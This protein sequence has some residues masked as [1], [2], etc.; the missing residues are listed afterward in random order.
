MTITGRTL[1]GGFKEEKKMS[2]LKK[3]ITIILFAV[4]A[5]TISFAITGF[6]AKAKADTKAATCPTSGV[7]EINDKV[8]LKLNEDGG[9]R[10]ILKMDEAHFSYIKGNE[11]VE[12]GF[13]IAPKILMD[14][15][16]EDYY[17]MQKKIVVTVDKEKIYEL[18]NKDGYHYA[19]GCVIN[20]KAVNRKYDY[21][22]AAYIK[23]GEKIE[24]QAAVNE[25]SVKSFYNVSNAAILYSGE[26]YSEKM[27]GLTA[28]DWL[29]TEEYPIIVSDS[30]RY[31]TLKNRQNSGFKDKYYE[32]STDVEYNA[33]DVSGIGSNVSRYG[34]ETAP[35]AKGGLIYTGSAQELVEAGTATGENCKIMYKVEGGEWGEFVPVAT[36]AGEY[37]VCYKAIKDSLETTEKSLTVNIAKAKNEITYDTDAN[38]NIVGLD[39]V[40]GNKPNETTAKALAGDITYT[41]TLVSNDSTAD[42][43]SVVVPDGAKYLP[44]NDNNMSGLYKCLITVSETENYKSVVGDR[45]VR[46]HKKE[47]DESGVKYAYDTT[48]AVYYVSGCE[49][50]VTEVTVPGIFNDGANGEHN[51]T[52][53]AV[54]AL[55]NKPQLKKVT[56]HE[57]IKSLNGGV[58]ANDVKLEY[59]LMTGVADLAYNSSE[60]GSGRGNNFIN[61]TALKYVIMNPAFTTDV[62]QFFLNGGNPEKAILDIYVDAASGTPSFAEGTNQN[63]L[64][65]NIYHK[66]D[67]AATVKCLQW[68]YGA[69][70]EIVKG[71]S[72]HIF[73]DGICSECGKKDAM[74]VV[75]TYDSA[76][77]CYYVAGYTGSGGTLNVFDT[78]N[79]GANGEA[80]VT[81]VKNSALINHTEIMKVILPASVKRLEGSVFQ[82]C[83]NLEYVSMVGVEE[84][85][86]ENLSNSGIYGNGVYSTNN[87][88]NCGKLKVVIVGKKFKITN[89][90]FIRTDDSLTA[91]LADIYM[92]GAEGECEFV[93]DSSNRNEHLSGNVYYYSEAELSGAWHY[94]NGVAMLWA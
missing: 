27:L 66:V 85:T 48:K 57:N 2:K 16:K 45:W 93:Y 73:V 46:V 80:A 72:G 7:F 32:F 40:Y 30:E 74:G 50:S 24:K 4:F 62:N 68:K 1:T 25:N 31:E 78:W 58:F 88:L 28:Y 5:L 83:S 39:F 9:M 56:L 8:G 20:M 15:A 94:V 3:K 75:Y 90:H 64:T 37:T 14:Q 13:V 81:Y 84:L 21:T 51:V 87:F 91:G 69:D 17:G 26:D 44:W 67:D 33:D 34:V 47:W 36:N 59:V 89:N 53:I 42:V 6:K 41:Y 38:G 79:D 29:G 23:N 10:W 63:L 43:G 60:Y 55:A 71:A 82:G 61:C 52:Y 18:T 19:N 76:K 77:S 11:A 65:G 35:V 22:A 54:E 49:N 12:L 70:G 86:L 92:S